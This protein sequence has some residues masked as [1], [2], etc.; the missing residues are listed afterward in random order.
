MA[1]RSVSVISGVPISKEVEEHIGRVLRDYEI[2]EIT[3]AQWRMAKEH[4][5]SPSY[6]NLMTLNSRRDDELARSGPMIAG[7][8]YNPQILALVKRA[9]LMRDLT[10]GL[11]EADVKKIGELDPGG[12]KQLVR[13]ASAQR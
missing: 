5:G 4:L 3:T 12:A 10:V 1:T 7:V 8:L 13:G 6:H 9:E 11:T 2:P